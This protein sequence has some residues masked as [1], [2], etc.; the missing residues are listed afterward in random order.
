METKW[1]YSLTLQTD[2]F[3]KFCGGVSV[4]IEGLQIFVRFGPTPQGTI[5]REMAGFSGRFPKNSRV[6]MHQTRYG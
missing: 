6:K 2:K 3:Q 4:W 1:D 5:T